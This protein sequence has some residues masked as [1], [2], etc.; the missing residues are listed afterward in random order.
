MNDLIS[1]SFFLVFETKIITYQFSIS[2]KLFQTL[3]Q[4]KISPTKFKSTPIYNAKSQY[5][6][7]QHIYK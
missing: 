1:F 6:C 7:L 3:K 5:A 4:V 2:N